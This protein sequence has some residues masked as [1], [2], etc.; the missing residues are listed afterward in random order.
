MTAAF[1]K[2]N[3][4]N[5]M[6]MK[7]CCLAICLL[8]QWPF[9]VLA[10]EPVSPPARPKV[11]LTLSGG[12][13]KGLAHIGV[14]QAIDSAGLTIDV[15]TGTSM[16]AVV[17]A[18]YAIGY[19]G[20]QIDS[21]AR[22]INWNTIFS[23]K[24]EVDRIP[25]D[26]K[27]ETEQQAF[28][29]K[30][31]RGKVQI[32]SGLIE[33]QELWLLL[34]ELFLPV[35]D[36]P[37]FSE[38]SVP[39][40]CVATDVLTGEPVLHEKGNLTL[41]VRSSMAIP[42]LFTAIDM[43]G[44]KLI[45]GGVVRNFPVRDAKEMGADYM[46]GVNVSAAKIPADQLNSALDILYQTAFI[47]S[48]NDFKEEIKLLD[49]FIDMDLG[50]YSAASFT[51]SDSILEIGIKAGLAYYP[52]F[53]RL[54]DSLNEISPRNFNACRLPTDQRFLVRGIEF[55]GLERTTRTSVLE[56]L[57][58][59]TGDFVT[60][61]FLSDR[62]REV[63]STRLYKSV[64]YTAEPHPEG[65]VRLRFRMLEHAP[66][67]FTAGIHY[68]TFS[69]I[70]ILTNY[71]VTNWFTDKSETTFRLN[72]GDN[73]RFLAKQEQ[74]LGKRLGNKLTLELQHDRV[75]NANYED[76]RQT[77]NY[78]EIRTLVTARYDRK[79]G[80]ERMAGIGISAETILWRPRLATTFEV[81]PNNSFLT[82]FYEF[83]M[84]SL[85]TQNFPEEGLISNYKIEYIFNQE[86]SFTLTMGDS[87]VEFDRTLLTY[88]PYFRASWRIEQYAKLTDRLSTGWKT[89][90][91][92]NLTTTEQFLFHNQWNVG[93]QYQLFR[94]QIPFVGF[95]DFQFHTDG[96]AS[97]LGQLQYRML[98]NLFLIG[99]G[100]VGIFDLHR[101][102]IALPER[103][104]F[105]WGTSMSVG[106]RSP[107]GPVDVSL[108]YN[109]SDQSFSGQINLG[110]WF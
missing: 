73:I 2:L 60:A 12:G 24:P 67:G 10:G 83:N 50:P 59:S 52:M 16:G 44:K 89:F 45:D 56:R 90:G 82:A 85:G 102:S 86:P 57:G 28:E 34:S 71:R 30:I 74:Y 33:S 61:K 72:L 68:N 81:R 70:A 11:S 29:L 94:N 8:L 98:D 107:I 1:N 91:G 69:N 43:D 96:F 77:Q 13:A 14:L 17:G 87:M 25:F 6:L 27:L 31:K 95:R 15:L 26:Q 35:Y 84:S 3:L 39:F 21:I 23:A 80:T 38:F 97:I 48:S 20:K 18:L 41:A 101:Y 55:E 36:R 110:W 22:S 106:Y 51:S 92:I 104:P 108:N 47:S 19:S 49:L 93:G 46:I 76:F 5:P 42:S 88:K 32:P 4:V 103:I 75:F 58:I 64:V 40:K 7:S 109:I 105:I 66:A 53:K 79:I 100:N 9:A 54:A 65:G 62:I 63:Y 78:R 99:R 37:E